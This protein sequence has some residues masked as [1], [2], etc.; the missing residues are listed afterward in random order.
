MTAFVDVVLSGAGTNGTAGLGALEGLAAAGV[1]PARVAGTSAG[2]LSAAC[3][4]AGLPY[5]D[6]HEITCRTLAGGV[7]DRSLW[8]LATEGGL[9]SGD[10][11]RRVMREVLPPLLSSPEWRLEWGAFAVHLERPG[12]C[13]YLTGPAA[14]VR[15]AAE[16]VDVQ[17]VNAPTDA[18]LMASCAIPGFFAA[19][20]IPGAR[21]GLYVDG[22]VSVGLGMAIFDDRPKRATV[23][24]RVIEADP[25]TEYRPGPP[26]VTST[27]EVLTT[28]IGALVAAAGRSYVSRK[29]YALTIDVVVQSSGLNF[30][31]P[32]SE[33][34]R[35]RAVGYAQGLAAGERWR[36]LGLLEPGAV[37]E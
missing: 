37:L 22:G 30:A 19:Q 14:T 12:G 2:S 32:R 27:R 9:H 8:A 10:G 7:L 35:L 21:P 31:K 15:D 25:R 13:D 17:R 11:L 18:V 28:S 29:R 23:G 24:I 16:P 20:A 3:V 5:D 1:L 26:Q 36:S 6:A 4:A 33:L 34:D